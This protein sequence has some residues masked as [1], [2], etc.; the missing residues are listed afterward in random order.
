MRASCSLFNYPHPL[1]P[2][3]PHPLVPP[4]PCPPIPLSPCPLVPLSPCP[5]VP[6]SPCPLVPLSPRPLVPLSPHPLVPLSPHL[7]IPPSPHPS[8]QLPVFSIEAQGSFGGSESPFC[9]SSMEML[10]GDRTNA[11]CPS[12][13]GRLM[14]TPPF[15]K[16]SQVS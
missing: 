16:R 10:S 7:P 3:S 9:S 5:L 13:G 8:Y 11:M 14:V 2:L 6:L 15:F 12:R 1:V 4:S